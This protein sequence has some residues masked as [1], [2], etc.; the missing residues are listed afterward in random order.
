MD[1]TDLFKRARV[2]CPNLVMG[3]VPFRLEA[4]REINIGIAAVILDIPVIAITSHHA[5][6]IVD[7]VF[8]T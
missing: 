8:N 2:D 7:G 6:L 3:Q 5:G 4:T 1:T